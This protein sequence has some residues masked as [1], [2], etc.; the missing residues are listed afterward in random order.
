MTHRL[1]V[2]AALVASLVAPCSRDAAAQPRFD[3]DKT[4]G[5]LPK[6][7]VPS[8]YALFLDLDPERDT[9]TGRVDIAIDVRQ[10]VRFKVTGLRHLHEAC[11][12][13]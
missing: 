9:F 11:S 8:R 6:S 3:F 7:V 13:F 1:L 12:R 5:G 4:P 2:T 10:P